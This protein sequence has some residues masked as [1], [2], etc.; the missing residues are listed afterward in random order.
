MTTIADIR[1]HLRKDLPD[2]PVRP[3]PVEGPQTA[4]GLFFRFPFSDF[5]FPLG[6][7]Q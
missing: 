7:S 3:E 5:R 1:T 2:S 6:A 4:A